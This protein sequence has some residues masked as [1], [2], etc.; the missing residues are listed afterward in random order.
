MLVGYDLLL[1]ISFSHTRWQLSQNFRVVIFDFG[2]K[3]DLK[4]INLYQPMRPYAGLL[5]V[6]LV[7]V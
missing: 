4:L 5:C 7:A 3:T 2:K 6:Y 1:A